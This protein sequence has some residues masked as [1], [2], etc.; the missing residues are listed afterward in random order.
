MAEMTLVRFWKI[1]HGVE[2]DPAKLSEVLGALTRRE[3]WLFNE[4]F[5]LEHRQVLHGTSR[6]WNNLTPLYPDDLTP[7]AKIVYQ[8]VVQRCFCHDEKGI[9]A[10][11]DAVITDWTWHIIQQAD[12]N[13]TKL[14]AILNELSQAELYRFQQEFY[15]ASL[16]LV[17]ERFSPPEYAQ[18]EDGLIDLSHW[19]TMQGKEYYW[20]IWENPDTFPYHINPSDFFYG[21]AEKIFEEKYGQ[22]VW[23]FNPFT[24]EFID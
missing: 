12:K 2:N 20:S 6:K 1:I 18:S 8:T 19:I 22:R 24:G 5:A 3:M 7:F 23:Y 9:A 17:D 16:A 15:G 14:Q 4:I 10:Y 11:P 21:E 13:S